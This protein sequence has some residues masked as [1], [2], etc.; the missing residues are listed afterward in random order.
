[1]SPYH[2][3]L[4]H[5]FHPCL[6]RLD[7]SRAII[8]FSLTPHLLSNLRTRDITDDDIKWLKSYLDD[9]GKW[10][11]AIMAVRNF[12]DEIGITGLANV[13][14]QQKFGRCRY[15]IGEMETPVLQ[16]NILKGRIVLSHE[17]WEKRR[18]ET[19]QGQEPKELLL[20][21]IEPQVK[22][23]QKWKNLERLLSHL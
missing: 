13:V 4:P 9:I 2:L 14:P 23:V 3:T 11:T 18:L 19:P 15:D 8:P 1:M 22:N 5:H 21:E 16:G 17:E 6:V 7:W 10:E 12:L 20:E